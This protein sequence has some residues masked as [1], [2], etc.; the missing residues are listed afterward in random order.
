V[1]HGGALVDGRRPRGYRAMK[2]QCATRL[3]QAARTRLRQLMLIDLSG[4][5]LAQ[6]P[7]LALA[8]HARQD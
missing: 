8:S 2:T 1:D 4:H 6:A 7:N 3:H 5:S